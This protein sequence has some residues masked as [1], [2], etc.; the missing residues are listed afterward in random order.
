[1]HRKSLSIQ[2]KCNPIKFGTHLAAA[3]HDIEIR[4]KLILQ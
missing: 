3:L 2:S 1:M 4:I